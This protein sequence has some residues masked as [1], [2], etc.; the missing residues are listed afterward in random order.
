MNLFYLG[1]DLHL[2]RT[3]AVL[4]KNSGEVVDKRRIQNNEFGKYLE[5]VVPRETYA[6]IE[7]TRNWA[8]AYDLLSE[9]VERTELAHPKELRMIASAVVK[10]DPIDAKVLADLARLNFLPIAYAAPKEIRDLRQ[11]IRH[12]YWLVG[13]RTQAKNRIH[14]ALASYN[15]VSPTKD[16]FGVSGRE[17]LDQALESTRLATRRVIQDNLALIDFLS[18][19]IQALEDEIPLEPEHDQ[20]IKLLKTVPGVGP[21]IAITILAEI[22]DYRRFSSPKSLCHWAGLTPKVHKSDRLVRHGRISKQGSP[23]LRG[24]MT[25]A[26]SVASRSSKRWYLVHENMLP[27][28]GR[29]GAKVVVARR[30]LTVIYFMLKRQEPYQEDYLSKNDR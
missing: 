28:C 13:Q 15:L 10:D 8:F 16:L 14:A 3:Y 22:G 1:I 18:D 24:A 27:R 17:Y 2:R 25:R 23:Y 30:L 29:A 26:A 7:A 11:W 19:Q 9:H 21:I 6:V 5:E 12:R 4:M 20:S